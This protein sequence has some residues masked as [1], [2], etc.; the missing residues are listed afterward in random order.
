MDTCK[1]MRTDTT[2]T[3]WIGIEGWLYKLVMQKEGDKHGGETNKSNTMP[4]SQ[5][6]QTRTSRLPSQ[7]SVQSS[8]L[9]LYNLPL[10]K[11]HQSV[12]NP[13]PLARFLFQIRTSRSTTSPKWLVYAPMHFAS[14][15]SRQRPIEASDHCGIRHPKDSRMGDSEGMQ[16]STHVWANKV[17]FGCNKTGEVCSDIIERLGFTTVYALTEH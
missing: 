4:L 8:K 11:P 14:A 15:Q 13:R 12:Q 5:Q 6:A 10:T 3:K 2:K 17:C 9:C 16:D 7:I 1:Y